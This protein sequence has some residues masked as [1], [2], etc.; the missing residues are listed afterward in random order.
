M[1]EG[2]GDEMVCHLKEQNAEF[3]D[4]FAKVTQNFRTETIDFH[5][6]NEQKRDWKV[7]FSHFLWII[8]SM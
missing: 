6:T 8:R 3:G 7:T 5:V 1:P 2:D 4:V